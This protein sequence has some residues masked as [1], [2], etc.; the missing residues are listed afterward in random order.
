MPPSCLVGSV[1]AACLP[2]FSVHFF[3]YGIIMYHLRKEP[4]VSAS[5]AS[6][7]RSMLNRHILPVFG[8]FNLRAIKARELQHF[9]NDFSGKSHTQ[10]AMA[11]STLQSIFAAAMEDRIISHD[12]SANIKAPAVAATPEKRTLT[13]DE[14]SRIIRLFRTHEHGL[15]IAVMFYTGMRPG[16][17]RGL[18]WGDIDWTDDMIHVQRDADYAA[19]NTVGK[20]KTA[21]ADRYIPVSTELR[22][23][24][25]PKR[26]A[27]GVFVFPGRDG[28][29]QAET[30]AKRMWISLMLAA[31]LVEPITGK[32]CYSPGDIRSQYRLVI[33]PHAMRHNF[34]TMCWERGLDI[35][36]TMK[37]VGH[38]DYKTT[39]N[40]YTHL[41]RRHLDDAKLQL[42]SMFEDAEN[43]S[44]TRVAQVAN[45]EV[46][47]LTN[48][49]PKPQ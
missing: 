38:A 10:V 17:V 42:N 43:K 4:F 7:Y 35:M 15:Y 46:V 32:T 34:I 8:D 9:V 33:T 24:L 14:R 22:A 20:L 26:Q 28:K 13:D 19:K 36:L 39:R 2:D 16:E 48:K 30:T 41:S 49:P 44:C 31:G 18:Q 3:D 29:P 27:P 47:S 11:I 40:I 45:G 5:T 6:A 12:P 23:M 37:L 25:Y 21:A 1:S